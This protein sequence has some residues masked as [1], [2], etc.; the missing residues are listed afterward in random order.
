MRARVYP[1]LEDYRKEMLGLPLL[2]GMLGE[3]AS[4]VVFEGCAGVAPVLGDI[5]TPSDKA[6]NA[7]SQRSE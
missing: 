5:S 7:S 4:A 1:T 3:A 6:A 2:L